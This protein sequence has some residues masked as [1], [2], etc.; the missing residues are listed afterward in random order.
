MFVDIY[1]AMVTIRVSAIEKPIKISVF[2]AKF[3]NI[4]LQ[5]NFKIGRKILSTTYPIRCNCLQSQGGETNSK[6]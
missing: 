1:E 2:K 6:Y 3:V 5:K 4:T